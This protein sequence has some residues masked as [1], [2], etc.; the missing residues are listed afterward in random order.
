MQ[1]K[2]NNKLN[3][4]SF[5]E[6]WKNSGADRQGQHGAVFE[7]AELGFARE[8]LGRI[9]RLQIAADDVVLVAIPMREPQWL[10]VVDACIFRG[11][12]FV[13]PNSETDLSALGAMVQEENITAIAVTPAQWELVQPSLMPYLSDSSRIRVVVAEG[14]ERR[15]EGGGG[16]VDKCVQMD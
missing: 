13:L 11:A 15:A 4:K 5:R 2:N 6:H 14:E 8:H 1:N 16:N 3:T 7:E 10:E 12:D 9:K